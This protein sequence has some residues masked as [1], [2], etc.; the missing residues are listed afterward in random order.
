MGVGKGERKE[1]I[2]CDKPGQNISIALKEGEF[3]HM[4][5]IICPGCIEMCGEE[6]CASGTNRDR[7]FGREIRQK[8]N[9]D[10]DK[11]DEKKKEENITKDNRKEISVNT[12]PNK[13]S[14]RT[15]KS[16]AA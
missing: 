1:E 12:E 7:V 2:I 15:S 8:D 11:D 9:V 16:F 5:A 10:D 4:G 6:N 3:L 13:N 14:N